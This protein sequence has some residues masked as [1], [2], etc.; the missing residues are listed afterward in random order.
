MRKLLLVGFVETIGLVEVAPVLLRGLKHVVIV[1]TEVLA[2][3]MGSRLELRVHRKVALVLIV[4][5]KW[6]VHHKIILLLHRKAVAT[7]GRLLKLRN[8]IV[9]LIAILIIA[10][11][12]R[13]HKVLRGIFLK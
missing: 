13:G 4:V 9:L 1:H 10:L 8:L 2:I 12:V 11:F 7:E 6:L 3:G 5:L